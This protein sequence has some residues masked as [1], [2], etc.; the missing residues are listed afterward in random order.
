MIVYLVLQQWGLHSWC[1]NFWNSLLSFMSKIQVDLIDFLKW[2]LVTINSNTN[3]CT[4]I[5]YIILP[6]LVHC[7]VVH[8]VYS[9]IRADLWP[10]FHIFL[11]FNHSI[12]FHF[13]LLL[14]HFIK[15]RA[16]NWSQPFRTDSHIDSGMFGNAGFSFCSFNSRAFLLLFPCWVMQ[17]IPYTLIPGT[18]AYGAPVW[19]NGPSRTPASGHVQITR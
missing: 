2:L 5:V 13:S 9:S 17:S 14:P 7:T 6:L 1:L 16:K 15:L 12:I 4:I 3:A 18:F 19:A 8:L 10:F 11:H